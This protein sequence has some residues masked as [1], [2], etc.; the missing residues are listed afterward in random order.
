MAATTIAVILAAGEGTRMKSGLP[1]VLHKV[2]GRSLLGHALL[3]VKDAGLDGA[4]VVIGPN[5]GKVE[6]EV[7]SVLSGADVF[8]QAERRGTA[9][10]VLQARAAIARGHAAIV[11]LFADTPLV[12]S[13]TVRR[14]ADAVLKGGDIGVMCF[15]AKDP[16]GYGRILMEGG[17]II[18]IREQKDAT[19]AERRITL[20]SG[21]LMSFKGEHALRILDAI[22]CN[23]AQNE[24]YLTAAV[25]VARRMG[26]R[27][28]PVEVAEEEA[29]G[30]NDRA[31]LAS[32]EAVVQT[33]LRRAALLAGVTLQAP[34]TVYFS[35]DTRLGCDVVIEPNV[36]FGPGVTV[37]DGVV[38]HAFSHLEGAHV[39]KGASVGPFARLRPGA[40]LAAE[41]KVG[42]FVEIKNASVEAGAKI[43]HLSYIG[44]ARIGAEANIGAGTIT[45][46][47]DG[48][49]K[50]VTDIG[51]GAFIGSNSSLVAPVTIG[52]G[53]FVG[54]GSVVTKDV[55][56]DAL[57]VARGHQMVKAGWARSFRAR[58]ENVA[59]ARKKKD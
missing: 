57:A 46:N 36:Y 16:T 55:P 56:A 13:E 7:R 26:L 28:V 43:S 44:D 52:D 25:E 5:H 20:C 53:A 9:H 11:V 42:N 48:Y 23:N 32:A 12:R 33:R 1:K 27:A 19:E 47:Y 18:A 15:R 59:K 51:A 38:I 17:E 3:G 24:Y 37:G 49:R 58:P 54:S 41:V 45:C 22:D 10:A 4:A 6:D 30:V 31:Q 40:T 29:F 21:G 50:F 35:A 8:V 39:G 2:A 14:L 34:G